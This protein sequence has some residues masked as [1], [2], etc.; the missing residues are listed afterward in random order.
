MMID[1]NAAR[2]SRRTPSAGIVQAVR[3]FP[4]EWVITGRQ[5]VVVGRQRVVITRR[6]AH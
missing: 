4:D 6:C 1:G 5:Q 3:L 2:R